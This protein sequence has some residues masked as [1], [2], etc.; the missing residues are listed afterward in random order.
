MI[1]MNEILRDTDVRGILHTIQVPTLLLHSIDNQ[2]EPI[3]EG[4]FIANQIPGAKLVELPLAEH[5][6]YW[7]A[8][9][10]VV[11]NVERFAR[12]IRNDEVEF[13]RVLATVLFTDIV[14][15]TKQSAALGD[16]AWTEARAEHDQ[17]IRANLSRFRGHE[18][19]TMGDGFLATFDGPARGSDALRPS[20][21][22]CGHS[23]SRSGPVCTPGRSR[24][25]AMT[26]VDSG[27]PSALVLRRSLA[28]PRCSSL[29]R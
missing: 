21:R 24:S 23:G 3:D 29:R 16:R 20:L 10:S 28:L 22:Q 17:I 13:E 11:A 18:V 15:S 6:P 12:Q 8:A 27:L 25:R 4:R 2:M 1:A 26:S 5:M 9:D 19:K 7:E 14:D